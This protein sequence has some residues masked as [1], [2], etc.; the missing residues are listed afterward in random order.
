MYESVLEAGGGNGRTT[1]LAPWLIEPEMFHGRSMG[2]EASNR[3]CMNTARNYIENLPLVLSCLPRE[4]HNALAAI[5]A[6]V[7]IAYE[8]T[9]R[10][11]FEGVSRRLLDGWENQLSLCRMQEQA[12]PVFIA[13][14]DTMNRFD[15]PDSPL[16]SVLESCRQSCGMRRFETFDELLGFC[17][18]LANPIGRLSMKI[19]G[20]DRTDFFWWA[21]KISTAVQLTCF[22]R[23]IS[24][25][26]RRGRINIP[27][28]DMERFS[29][30]EKTLFDAD[31]PR[32][33]SALIHLEVD[34]TRRL[35][36]ES[37]PLVT[38]AGFPQNAYFAGLWLGGRSVL[39]LVRKAR[40]QILHKRPVLNPISFM[41]ALVGAGIDRLPGFA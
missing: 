28:E 14:Q 23:D 33:F 16:C 39:R 9:A 32:T 30:P 37:L 15:L 38:H 3:F 8:F 19:F 13:L 35:F 29:I 11:E 10:K 40:G 1:G 25:D 22:W 27:L 17:R 41:R 18:G 2:L 5:Y 36:Q 34:R 7:S 24:L 4:Q 6:F 31:S 12:H 26:L 20:V 21:D